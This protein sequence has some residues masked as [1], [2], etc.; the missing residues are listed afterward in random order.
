MTWRAPPHSNAHSR[1]RRP[2]GRWPSGARSARFARLA[3]V[4]QPAAGVSPA[5]GA[6][7]DDDA[8]TRRPEGVEGGN[9][10]GPNGRDV[11]QALEAECDEPAT[12]L[13]INAFWRTTQITNRQGR[14]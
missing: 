3:A 6:F 11:W 10:N 9:V 1:P 12:A 5:D 7:G 2:G 8:L 14:R 4:G 13:E